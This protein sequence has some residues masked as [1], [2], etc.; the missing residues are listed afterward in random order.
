MSDLRRKFFIDDA[1]DQAAQ[2]SCGCPNPGGAASPQALFVLFWSPPYKDIKLLKSAQR[3]AMKLGRGLEEKKYMEPLRSLGLLG[4]TKGRLTETSWQPTTS[5]MVLGVFLTTSRSCI[6]PADSVP[7]T[8]EKKSLLWC[9]TLPL[10]VIQVPHGLSA[11]QITKPHIQPCKAKL[12]QELYKSS[13]S[14]QGKKSHWKDWK[15]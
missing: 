1:Q 6:Q 10:G 11:A 9:L 13:V 5:K 2:G 12:D 3:W 8:H 14:K 15:T 7:C 4:P